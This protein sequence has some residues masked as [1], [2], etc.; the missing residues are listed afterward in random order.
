MNHCV[1]IGNLTKD[2]EMVS[3]PSGVPKANGTIAVKRPHTKDETDF[4]YI[5][6]WRSVAET[7]SKY[8]GKGSKVALNGYFINKSYETESGSKKSFFCFIVEEVEFIKV[9]KGSESFPNL[10]ET[11]EDLPF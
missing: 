6:A 9:I 4:F 3:L 10:K 7:M 11:D 5:E 2:M 8:C 1:L